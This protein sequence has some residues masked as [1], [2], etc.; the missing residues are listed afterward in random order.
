MG[1]FS[2]KLDFNKL[3]Y[4]EV[5]PA[6]ECKGGVKYNKKINKK[7]LLK[8]AKSNKINLKYIFNIKNYRY[9]FMSLH[10]TCV[11]LFEMFALINSG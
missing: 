5:H 3:I 10:C 8:F 11:I 2:S 4:V 9:F 1:V 6:F 7:D